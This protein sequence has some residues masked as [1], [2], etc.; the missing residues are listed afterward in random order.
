MG[1]SK[2]TFPN[3]GDGHVLYVLY[4]HVLMCFLSTPAE[5]DISH[6]RR[7]EAPPEHCLSVCVCDCETAQVGQGVQREREGWKRGAERRGKEQRG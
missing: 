2:V 7:P 3:S 5:L 6:W 1:S 4:A